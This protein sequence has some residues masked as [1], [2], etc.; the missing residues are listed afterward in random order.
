MLKILFSLITWVHPWVY[1]V[2]INTFQHIIIRAF[3]YVDNVSEVKLL[4]VNQMS[5]W[6]LMH[7]RYYCCRNKIV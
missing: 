5:N 4:L 6:Y 3:L 7:V 1:E 2:C